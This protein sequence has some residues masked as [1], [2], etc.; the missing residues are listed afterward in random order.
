[1]PTPSI[2]DENRRSRPSP[3][4]SGDE[5]SHQLGAVS[6]TGRSVKEGK[7]MS[8]DEKVKGIYGVGV[9]KKGKLTVH[10]EDLLNSD[11]L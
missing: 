2:I 10:S 11:K 1:M 8:R 7:K 4:V 3:G 5:A 6:R 9:L